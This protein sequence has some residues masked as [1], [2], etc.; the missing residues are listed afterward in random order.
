MDTTSHNFTWQIDTLGDG[1]GSVLYDVAIINNT[2]A[3]TVGEIYKR[4]SVGNW[5]PLPSGLALWNGRSWSSRKVA[6]EDLYAKKMANE[7]VSAKKM[8]GNHLD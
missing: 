5:D 3:Y 4:D 7:N 1:G 6:N 2:L 8:A